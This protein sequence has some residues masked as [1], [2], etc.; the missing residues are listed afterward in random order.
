MVSLTEH[1]NTRMCQ[2]CDSLDFAPDVIFALK[3][4]DLM[5]EPFCVNS[6]VAK[7]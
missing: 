4:T 7:N 6:L 2:S 5:L 1:Y 3:E